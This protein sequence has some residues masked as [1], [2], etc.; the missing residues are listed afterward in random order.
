MAEG[1]PLLAAVQSMTVI[2]QI[3]DAS[4]TA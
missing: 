4:L 1:K 2:A 3:T